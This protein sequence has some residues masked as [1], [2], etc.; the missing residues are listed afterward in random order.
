MKQERIKMDELVDV[1]KNKLGTSVSLWQLTYIVIY[2]KTSEKIL[3]R[4][5]FYKYNLKIK[6][7]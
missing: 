6:L 5:I 1:L 2:S 4:R 3:K 7:W